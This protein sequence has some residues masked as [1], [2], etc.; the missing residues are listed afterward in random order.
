MPE[1]GWT[2]RLVDELLDVI[3]ELVEAL[4]QPLLL[5][6]LIAILAIVV[7]RYAIGLT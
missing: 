1:R 5:T 2:V 4:R 7:L 6:A 3:L